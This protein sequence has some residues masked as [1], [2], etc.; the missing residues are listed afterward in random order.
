MRSGVS[1]QI[2]RVIE[3]L[4]AEGAQVALDVRMAFHVPIQ[5]SLQGET[6][7]AEAAGEFV[8]VV[9][10]GSRV[11]T[12]SRR[13]RRTGRNGSVSSASAVVAPLGRFH[14][15]L[16][17]RR[18]IRFE[19]IACRVLAVVVVHQWIFNSMSAVDEFQWGVIGQAQLHRN[20]L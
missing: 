12:V 10:I 4:P 8:G 5:Q 3:T 18:R 9:R 19:S 11:H 1:F 13:R 7:G 17:P 6:L 15:D 16:S 20:V 14:V 2:E